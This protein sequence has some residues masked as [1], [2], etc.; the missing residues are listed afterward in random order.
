MINNHTTSCGCFR[1]QCVS[2]L[3]KKHGLTG[4]R[5][6]RIW[7]EMN[8]RCYLESDTNFYKYGKRGITVCDEWKND[9]KAFYDWAMANGYSD[10][11]TL[12]R[13]DNNKGYCPENCRWATYSEQ[14]KNRRNF[15]RGKK[16]D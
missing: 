9:F 5:I 3:N 4:T 13:I 11:L 16:R 15:K 2:K 7:V 6:Y 14:N 1:K 12:D 8:H 10:E